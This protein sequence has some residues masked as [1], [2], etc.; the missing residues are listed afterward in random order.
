MKE[1]VIF[2][3]LHVAL[4]ASFLVVFFFSYVSKIEN[5]IVNDQVNYLIDG[6]TADQKYFITDLSIKEAIRKSVEEMKAPDLSS[7]DEH[8]YQ[9]NKALKANAYQI[10]L[11][12][13]LIG[14]LIFMTYAMH[15]INKGDSRS[16]YKMLITSVILL[17][18][19]ALTEIFFLNCIARKYINVDPNYFRNRIL[20][21]LN[22]FANT[23]PFF[24]SLF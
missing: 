20:I 8:V 18:A 21:Q 14:V 6:F 17:F 7:E 1:E 9:R 13:F 5:L 15:S 10:I 19:I 12:V 16:V 2:I 11:A 24:L 3:F 23:E 22:K 4:I